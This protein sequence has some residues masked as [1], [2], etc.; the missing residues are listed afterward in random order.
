MP[1]VKHNQNEKGIVVNYRNPVKKIY[2]KI[3]EAKETIDLD[4]IKRIILYNTK[5]KKLLKYLDYIDPVQGKIAGPA[6]ENLSFP[7]FT[8]TLLHTIMQQ[9]HQ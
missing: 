8:T 3:S 9:I 4:K 6:E 7:N 2:N 5:T 1:D